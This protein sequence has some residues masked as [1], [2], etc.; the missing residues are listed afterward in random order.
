MSKETL[1]LWKKLI[2]RRN[3]THFLSSIKLRYLP[4]LV[5]IWGRIRTSRVYPVVPL[6][7]LQLTHVPFVNI[8]DS[9]STIWT[10]FIYI[11]LVCFCLFVIITHEPLDWFASNFKLRKFG[12][13][14]WKLAKIVIYDKERLISGQTMKIYTISK[15]ELVKF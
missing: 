8:S 4:P 13:T 5:L 15:F 11:K 12:R 6:L 2:F 10:I 3:K 1:G 7:L 9:A 14:T